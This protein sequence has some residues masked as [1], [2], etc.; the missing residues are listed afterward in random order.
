MADL[1]TDS[2]TEKVHVPSESSDGTDTGEEINEKAL[3]RK[4]DAKLLP[5]VGILYLLS[6]LDRSNGEPT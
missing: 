5:A 1:R 4:I 3:L 2:S 6:F